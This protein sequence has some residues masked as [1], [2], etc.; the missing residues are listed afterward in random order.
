M[1]FGFGRG[2]IEILLERF[3]FSPGEVIKG[4]VSFELKKP[5]LARQLKITFAGLRT[6]TRQII[7]S[8]G[9]PSTETK[10]DFIYHFE[11]PLDGEKEYLKGEYPFEIKIP[12]DVLQRAPK[13]EGFL[14]T[15]LKGVKYLKGTTTRIDWYLEACLDIPKAFDI[16]KRVK[17]NIG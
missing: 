17:I 7:T 5:V 16:K 15:L 10:R 4:K 9:T 14:G 12:A 8:K 2:K 13:P 6:I 3:N 11:M 1:I